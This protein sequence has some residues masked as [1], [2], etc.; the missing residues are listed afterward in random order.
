MS[1]SIVRASQNYASDTALEARGLFQ[2]INLETICNLCTE[3]CENN[4]F[5]YSDTFDGWLF[6]FCLMVFWLNAS[7][8]G[9]M[10]LL[11]FKDISVTYG[12]ATVQ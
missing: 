9:H 10:W 4:A 3:K 7:S 5:E 1:V 2:A 12:I 6:D 8:M 11:R